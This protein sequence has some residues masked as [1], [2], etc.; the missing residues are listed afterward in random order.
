MI[1][2]VIALAIFTGS[3]SAKTSHAG[4]KLTMKQAEA[5][6]LKTAPGKIKSKELEKEKGKLIY[7]FDIETTNDGIHE[8]NIDAKTGK[9]VENSKESPT[10]EAQEKQQDQQAKKK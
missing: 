10:A 4:A 2:A 3:A 5:M 1:T 6:A 7:S 9:L 8:V